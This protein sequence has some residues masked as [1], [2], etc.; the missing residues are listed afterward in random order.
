MY[1]FL[2]YA[3]KFE[4]NSLHNVFFG[5]YKPLSVTF[6]VN[7]TPD[8]Q[9]CLKSLQMDSNR[10]MD[11]KITSPVT[12]TNEVGQETLLYPATFRDRLGKFTSAIF[13]NIRLASGANDINQIH[14]GDDMTGQ[15]LTFELTDSS[16]SEMQLRVVTVNF[17]INE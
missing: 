15:Y 8:I 17:S 2:N 14:K 1:G 16:S 10:A 3:W 5:A 6:V 12:N 7:S 11:V 4:S 9:K 13:K